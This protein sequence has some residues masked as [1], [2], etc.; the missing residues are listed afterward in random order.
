MMK[1]Y[2]GTCQNTLI[3]SNTE[4]DKELVKQLFI[5]LMNEGGVM[6]QTIMRNYNN[7]QRKGE[8]CILINIQ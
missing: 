5:T 2:K 3:E 8:P 6:A 4:V 7:K 1:N